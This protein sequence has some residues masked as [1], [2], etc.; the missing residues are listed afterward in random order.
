MADVSVASALAR[1]RSIGGR[2][3]GAPDFQQG[4]EPFPTSRDGIYRVRAMEVNTPKFSNRKF[5]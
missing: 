1:S 4:I 2:L 3:T 5:A